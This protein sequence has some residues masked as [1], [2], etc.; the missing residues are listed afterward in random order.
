MSEPSDEADDESAEDDDDDLDWEA[1]DRSYEGPKLLGYGPDYD[2]SP[3]REKTR[4]RLALLLFAL[5]AVVALS[6]IGLTA[7]DALAEGTTKDLVAGILSP[8]IVL[9][10][11]ALGFYFGGHHGS[12]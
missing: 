7:A 2:P 8:L 9:T 3:L 4:S 1:V 5:V 10:G 11:T 6:L 12:K